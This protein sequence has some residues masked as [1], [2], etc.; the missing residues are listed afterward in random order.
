MKKQ[1]WK[2]GL[3]AAA[4][5]VSLA[6][7]GHAQSVD[8][9]LDKLV[10]KGVLSVEEA[11]QLREESD[12]GFNTA[13][14]SRL[15]MPEW[16]TSLKFNGD[17]RGRFEHFSSENPAFADR[18]R[19]RY[20]L[21]FGVTAT[22]LEDF[23]AGFRLTSD[24]AATGGSNNE[25]D[26]ISGNTT[27]QNNASKK[28]VYIDQAYGKW[29]PLNGPRLSGSATIGKMENP[30]VFSDMIFDS[31]YTPEG[32]AIQMAY[33][34]DDMHTARLNFGAF[35][36]DEISGPGDDP[37][38]LGAQLRWDGVWSPGFKTSFGAAWLGICNEES[39]GNT[40]VPN[41]QR[42]NSRVVN[43]SSTG[44]TNLVPAATFGPFVL[45]ASAT[46]MLEKA[47][48][49]PGRFPFKVSADY[50]NNCASSVGV[51]KYGYS[52]GIT[53]GKAGKRKTW[54]VGY[55]YK[56]LGADAWWE[57]LVDSDF[58]GFYAGGLSNSGLGSGYG[59][60]TNVKGHIVRFAYSPADSLTLSVKWINTE[61]INPV[62]GASESGM[63]RLQVDAQ[64][65]F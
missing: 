58:G 5:G 42:G 35:V 1:K 14:S 40:T 60:G 49:Y 9:L 28:L 61:L 55:T 33:R 29:T 62:P 30:F 45:D 46:Y 57:E 53:F 7:S 48:L 52:T 15:G 17:V 38:L 44:A 34:F 43:V 37:Y 39:L 65:K 23:E 3:L 63:D 25:G 51:D 19:F 32:G 56:W 26:P 27:F 20:R 31:D 11:N 24:E 59:P 22:F 41:G 6:S 18:N 13:L 2:A 64:W 8:A 36:L 4:A 12:N 10:D 50:I 16:V 21:R 54:E 47:P